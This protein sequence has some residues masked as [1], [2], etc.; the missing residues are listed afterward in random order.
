M[1]NILSIIVLHVCPQERAP[2]VR[3][4]RPGAVPP[5]RCAAGQCY[6]RLLH[7]RQRYRAPSAHLPHAPAWRWISQYCYKKTPFI[8]AKVSAMWIYPTAAPRVL[9]WRAPVGA[10]SGPNTATTSSHH[11]KRSQPLPPEKLQTWSTA[12]WVLKILTCC[13]R[14]LESS[15]RTLDMLGSKQKTMTISQWI[16]MVQWWVTYQSWVTF[17]S[18]ETV[19]LPKFIPLWQRLS[20]NRIYGIQK[21]QKM[22][23]WEWLESWYSSGKPWTLSWG[24]S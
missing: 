17:W 12:W 13:I 6:H 23:G 4:Q 15:Y 11:R 20:S 16:N 7:P 24:P 5:G 8:N 18:K 2:E 22:L 9:G 21:T 19:T 10:W 1:H 14:C 3:R